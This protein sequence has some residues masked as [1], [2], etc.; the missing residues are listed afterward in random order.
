MAS[1]EELFGL[2]SDSA[3]RNR[4]EIAMLSVAEQVRSEAETTANHLK[5]LGWA[6][7]ILVDPA[8]W[9]LPVF[10]LLL[11]ANKALDASAIIKAAEAQ[12]EAQIL[13]AVDFFATE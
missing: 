10:R 1:Y 4:V 2:Y 12:I 8:S 11:V 13:G 6:R 7:S 9:L 5:R 3:F